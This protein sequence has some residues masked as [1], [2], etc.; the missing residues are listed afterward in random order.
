MV[1]SDYGTTLFNSVGIENSFITQIIL[2]AVNVV[3]TF[4][5]LYM[6]EKFGRR[7][8]LTL[9]A[10]WMAMCFLVFASV[11]KFMLHNDDGTTNQ[12]AGY[13]MIIF[14]CLFIAAFAST[15]GPMAWA[16]VA[17]MYPGRYRSQAI[18]YCSASNWFWN[19][20]LAFFTPL[21]NAE[22]SF[23]YGYV[24]AGCNLAAA[25][26][27]YFF[28]IE[29]NGKSLEQIDTMYLLHVPPRHSANW[30][31]PEG[32]DLITAERVMRERQGKKGPNTM[33]GTDMFVEQRK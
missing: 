2:G 31:A 10:L 33:G 9:G 4:P 18:S 17:E 23:A 7:K 1:N 12:T 13:L 22:I 24:F 29:S 5:G 16:C 6:V 27:V 3:C 30:E 32:E 21:I 25:I 20:Y 14:S 11:G 8:C 15:W 28:L 26:I 19:F